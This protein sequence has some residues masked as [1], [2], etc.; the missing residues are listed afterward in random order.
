MYSFLSSFVASFQS[1]IFVLVSIVTLDFSVMLNTIF[2]ILEVAVEERDLIKESESVDVSD[3]DENN[4]K[5]KLY[6]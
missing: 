1:S 4:Q 5:S 2:F 3:A 6:F